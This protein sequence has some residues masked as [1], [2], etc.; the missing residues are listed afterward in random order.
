MKTKTLFAAVMALAIGMGIG[1]RH[2][3]VLERTD[4]QDSGVWLA[5]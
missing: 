2:G 5:R 1:H 4:L 3:F